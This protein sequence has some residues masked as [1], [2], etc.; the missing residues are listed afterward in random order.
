MLSVSLFFFFFS[1]RANPV[2]AT[3]D[4]QIAQFTG[5]DTIAGCASRWY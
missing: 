5:A 1:T 4:A 3:M 2:S